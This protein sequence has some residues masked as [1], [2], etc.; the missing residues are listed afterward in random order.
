MLSYCSVLSALHYAV[1][2]FWEYDFFLIIIII[3]TPLFAYVLAKWIVQLSA[4]VVVVFS[5]KG[6]KK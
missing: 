2:A 4:L 6:L 3:N 5:L 1:S